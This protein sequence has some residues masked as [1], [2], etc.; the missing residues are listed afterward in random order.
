MTFVLVL[1]RQTRSKPIWV[2]EIQMPKKL[3][4]DIYTG[5]S[6]QHL[7]IQHKRQ[8]TTEMQRTA[9]RRCSGCSGRAAPEAEAAV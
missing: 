3:I 5:I 8:Y 7:L 2:V 4:A 1:K 9:S 6:K